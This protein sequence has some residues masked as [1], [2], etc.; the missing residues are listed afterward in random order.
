MFDRTG[1]RIGQVAGITVRLHWIFLLW[2]LFELLGSERLGGSSSALMYLGFLFGSV[3]LHELGHCRAA[4]QIG[5]NAREVILW[6]LGGLAAV[7]IPDRPLSHLA[8]AIGGPAV[9]LILWL[10]LLPFVISM[11]GIEGI[12]SFFLRQPVSEP[13]AVAAAVNLDLFVFNLLPALPLDGGRILHSFIWSRRGEENANR[14]LVNSGKFVALALALV[15]FVY[16]TSGLL[17]ALAVLMWINSLHI[18]RM[19][20]DSSGYESWQ[21]KGSTGPGWWQRQKDRIQQ[22][23]TE[24]SL[25]RERDIRTRVDSLLE[26]VS[27]EGLEALSSEERRFLDDV[28]RK[29]ERPGDSQRNR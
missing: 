6:P 20:A 26:K 18:Q 1:L 25:Q 11:E 7:D 12:G 28:S 2:G 22:H 5:G 19:L 4:R 24:K 8:V 29:Y 9:N 27:K 17:L 3:F 23:Q 16:D 10:A 13:I 21:G 14:V 15:W